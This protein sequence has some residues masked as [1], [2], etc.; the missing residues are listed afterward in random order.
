LWLIT[1]DFLHFLEAPTYFQIGWFDVNTIKLE[2]LTFKHQKTLDEVRE[3]EE[4]IHQTMDEPP[5]EKDKIG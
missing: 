1:F 3:S 4:G 2:R 5:I